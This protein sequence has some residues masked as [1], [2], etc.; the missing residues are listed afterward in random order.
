M[1]YTSTRNRA[2]ETTA[3]HAITQGISVDGGLFVPT[4]LPRFADGELRALVGKPYQ[5]IA[6]TVLGK[7][8]TDFTP[9]EVAACVDSA[10]TKERFRSPQ[11]A[12]LHPLNEEAQVLELW[13]G[14]T[15]AF[16]DMALQILPHLM[17]VSAEK[18]A[19]GRE[20]VILVATSG[21]TGKAALEGFR[22]AAHTRILVFYPE[23]GV[24]EMQ[25]L[26]MVTQEGQN[27]AVC[28]IRGNFD[29][30]QTG[31]KQIFTDPAMAKTL[32]AHGMQFS[33]ANSIN[34]GRLVPQIVYYVSAYC[35]MVE[36]GGVSWG[37][38]IDVVVPTGN[39]GNILAAYY[40][41]RMGVP[42][43]KLV[44]ASNRNRV[45]TDFLQTGTY[46]RNRPFYT[47]TSPS[48]DILISSNLERLLYH[49]SGE[50]DGAVRGMMES[51][52][53]T[54]KYTVP[55]SVR[56]AL[57]EL[58]DAGWCDDEQTA[59][60]IRET[61]ETYGYLLDT[62]TAVAVHVY[63]EYRQRAGDGVPA[64]IA[65]TANPYKFPASVLHALGG[66]NP[67]WD[68][69][70]KAQ[71]LQVLTGTQIP[72]PLASLRGKS[73]RFTQVC[74]RDGMRQVVFGLLGIAE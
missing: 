43:R 4:E 10:Y 54:G 2:V 33:S 39:F 62:H 29:D 64:V 40:A 21:D 57:S 24:S 26:Q 63:E 38:E 14:P 61:Y 73:P 53:Q 45:L 68:E 27:V 55:E 72:A 46:D 42:I 71:R 65:S 58:F 51:L 18:T 1:R 41:K 37:N 8:L 6:R 67:V 30:A 23:N 9:A 32:A 44:C 56:T 22:D 70:E 5:E 12:P 19:G 25:K 20:I 49:L 15:C 52:R 35:G 31:V 13:H 36:N 59:R 7:F 74:D 3:A 66:D 48:M 16:K 69:F 34:W 60:T 50:D 17:R 47:T 11:I 28:A